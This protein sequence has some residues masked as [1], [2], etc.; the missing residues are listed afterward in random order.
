MSD[1]VELNVGGMHFTT[2]RATLEES[3]PQSML[4]ALVSGRHGPP[5]RDARVRGGESEEG[6][7]EGRG[8]GSGLWST[9]FG[10]SLCV[11]GRGFR[12]EV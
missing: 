7:E 6:Q 4:A 12:V 11:E 10:Y 3:Q 1:L 9:G 2:N 5:R 8:G